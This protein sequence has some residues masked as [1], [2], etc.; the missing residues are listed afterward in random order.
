M[1]DANQKVSWSSYIVLMFAVVIFSG[2]LTKSAPPW[3][4]LDFNT[5][6]GAFG[7]ISGAKGTFIGSKGSGARDG[8]LFTMSLMPSVILALGLVSIVEGY[9]GLAAAQKLI[10]P[11]F[12]PILGIPGAC[13]L[14]FITGLQSSDGGAAMAKALYDSGTITDKER[15]ILCMLLL[16]GNGTITN[17]FSSV[18]GLFLFFA[19]PISLPLAIIF[20]CKFFGVILMRIVL[21]FDSKRTANQE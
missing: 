5:L 4:V 12:R 16:S 1:A 2:L 6:T 20:L 17:Y 13:G 7:T 10:T 14:A 11:I 8:F 18:G 15:T 9:G 19:V 21:A 3:N